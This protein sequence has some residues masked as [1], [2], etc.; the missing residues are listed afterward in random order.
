MNKKGSNFAGN[1]GFVVFNMVIAGLVLAGVVMGTMRW[2]R[3][4]TQFGVEITVPNVVGLYPEEAEM[5]LAAA[6]L[7]LQVIDS[8]F[9]QKTQL[10]TFMEQNPKAGSKV[11]NGRTIYV[12]QNA[13]VRRPVTMPEL[14][15]ISLRQAEAKIK[16]IGM[17]V[18]TITYEPSAYKN[19]IIDMRVDDVPILAGSQ[20][21]EGTII[22]LIVGKGLGNQQVTVP[23]LVGKTLTEARS[24]LI[25]NSLTVGKTTYDEQ[26]TEET[27]G[28]H[29]VYSQTPA[30]GE[31]VRGGTGIN[32]K[33]T[34]D[35]EKIVSFTPTEESEEEFF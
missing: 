25:G 20:V 35:L 32:L 17:T 30:A 6:G 7:H 10:G 28:Q 15:D 3:S 31:V 18:G 21:P 8:T 13:S 2:L 1:V 5:T 4:Y 33:L 14:R 26:P 29:I 9:S 27:L 24:W 22:N 12:I 23:S 16:A 11:K 34:T 19:L